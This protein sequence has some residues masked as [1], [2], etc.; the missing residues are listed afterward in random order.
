LQRITTQPPNNEQ[1]EVA[2]I[3]MKCAL[4][5]DLSEYKNITFIDENSQKESW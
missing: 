1:I 5:M 2:V 4:D 3:A